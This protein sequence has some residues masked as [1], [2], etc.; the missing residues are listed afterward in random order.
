MRWLQE[1]LE[2]VPW[3][4]VALGSSAF[5]FFW[6]SYLDLRQIRHLLSPSIPQILQESVEIDEARMKKRNAW[7]HVCQVLGISS[8]PR[9]LFCLADCFTFLP[10]H[11]AGHH[12]TDLQSHGGHHRIHC[13]GA[14]FEQPSAC[15]DLDCEF[16]SFGADP[17]WT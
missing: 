2:A 5:F 12:A 8:H 11:H 14:H 7:V 3:Y 15:V 13:R 1:V 16:A 4:Y 10:P 9:F 6:E 17:A